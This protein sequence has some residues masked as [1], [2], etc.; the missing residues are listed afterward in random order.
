M[1]EPIVEPDLNRFRKNI[2]SQF[3]EDGIVE[4]ILHRIGR[5]SALDRWCVEFGAW[6]GFHHSNTCNLIKNKDYQAV[7]IEGD[8]KKYREL[9]ANFPSPGVVKVCRFVTFDGDST[10]D[11]ILQTTPI[12]NDF[13]FLSID[14]DGCDYFIFKS[15]LLY[16]PKLICI[17]FNPTVPNDV[18]FIQPRD[19]SIKQGSS[20]KSVTQLAATKGYALV[21]ATPCNLF[22]VRNE[23][24]ENVIGSNGNTLDLLRDDTQFKAYIFTGFDGTIF[25]D[26]ASIRM[27][28]HRI[29]IPRAALQQLPGFLRRFPPDY[30]LFQ[31]TG[32][33]ILLFL[34]FPKQFRTRIAKLTTRY[35]RKIGNTK[36]R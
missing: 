25:T 14:I 30:N 3:G 36:G 7:L 21:A 13:D 28:W 5:N 17:E 6:D 15:L 4:E 8:V 9:C 1:S 32:F 23:F 34:K 22:F 20:A 33:L 10:L 12:P 26:K 11:C 35:A 27:P 16:Q 24:R 18:E 29:E 19:F 31:K 2:H